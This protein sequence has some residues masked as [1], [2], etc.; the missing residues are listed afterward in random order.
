MKIY[1]D[2]SGDLGW[3]FDLP[4]RHGGSSRCLVLTF[5]FLPV[6]RDN[7]PRKIIAG[8]YSKYGWVREKKASTATTNQRLEFCQHVVGLLKEY[9]DIKIDTIIA[10]KTSLQ[11]HIREDG[12][13]LYNYMCGLVVPN[14]VEKEPVVEWIPD[15]RSIRVSSGNSLVDYL[16]IKL[17]FDCGYETKI[18]DNPKESHTDYNLQFVDWVSHC[19]WL[20]F[21]HSA[22]DLLNIL[23]PHIR[24]RRLF[25]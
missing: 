11:S 9:P 25:Y 10:N 23:R 12:N 7:K 18:L 21:E 24:I 3:K 20:N 6:V 4:F 13:K 22:P 19:V 15:K 1:L 5:L 16:Q 17:W 2:E 8:L 14:Y